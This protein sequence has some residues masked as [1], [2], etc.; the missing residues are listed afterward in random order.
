MREKKLSIRIG[1]KLHAE[2]KKIA[3]KYNQSISEFVRGVLIREVDLE[4]ATSVV[5]QKKMKKI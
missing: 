3:E 5:E 2:I 4:E 1:D